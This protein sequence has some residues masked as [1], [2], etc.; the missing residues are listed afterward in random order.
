M[1]RSWV[2]PANAANSTGL[3]C[4]ALFLSPNPGRLSNCRSANRDYRM[5]ISESAI[6]SFAVPRTTKGPNE[7]HELNGL[8]ESNGLRPR[9][10]NPGCRPADAPQTGAP[11]TAHSRLRAQLIPPIPPP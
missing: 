8:N 5:A 4:S 2:R 6:L 1:R 11:R 9:T 7:P 10:I 3:H